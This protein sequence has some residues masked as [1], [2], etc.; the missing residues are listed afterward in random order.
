MIMTID[1]ELIDMHLALKSLEAENP[2]GRS[3]SQYQGEKDLKLLDGIP[4]KIGDQI[5]V[6]NTTPLNNQA[7]SLL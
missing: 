2:F 1:G 4:L 7:A 5:T 6:R 3:S